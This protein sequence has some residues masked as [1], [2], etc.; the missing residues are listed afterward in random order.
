MEVVFAAGQAS[1]SDVVARMTE[2]P[3]RTTVRTILR[4]LEDKGHLRH[5]KVGRE[6]VYRP[7]KQKRREGQSAMHRV[8]NTFFGGSLEQ[9]VAA[10]L[11]DPAARLDADEMARLEAMIKAA[12]RRSRGDTS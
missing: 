1:V 12:R 2:P 5:K 9:A 6:F 10:H 4:I 8:L 3:T 11:A 7:V